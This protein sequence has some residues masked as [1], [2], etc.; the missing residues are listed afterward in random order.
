MKRFEV[1][2]EV[3]PIGPE[4]VERH[5]TDGYA[6]FKG[7]GGWRVQKTEGVLAAGSIRAQAHYLAL[8]TI[9][10]Y[11]L[12]RL[13]DPPVLALRDPDA[14]LDERPDLILSDTDRSYDPIPLPRAKRKWYQRAMELGLGERKGD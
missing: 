4:T 11:G 3:G 7:R 10:R 6:V 5:K 13:T 14:G 2:I 8:C 9:D 12:T 1:T